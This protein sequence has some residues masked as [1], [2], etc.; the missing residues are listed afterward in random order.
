MMHLQYILASGTFCKSN[1]L[2]TNKASFVLNDIIF[3]HQIDGASASTFQLTSAVTNQIYLF[4]YVLFCCYAERGKLQQ[5]GSGQ[6]IIGFLQWGC[7]YGCAK[8]AFVHVGI[9]QLRGQEEGVGVSM[10]LTRGHVIKVD[11][12]C[13]MSIFVHSRG[14][15]QRQVNFGQ[16]SC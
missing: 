6:I 5:R 13:K 9:Q 7:V 10:K 16:R 11:I 14:G 3:P 15:G 4:A 8:A 12:I 2:F 1:H